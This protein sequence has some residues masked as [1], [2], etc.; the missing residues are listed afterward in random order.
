MGD[1][2]Y[3]CE[4]CGKLY[5]PDRGLNRNQLNEHNR[6]TS[7]SDLD[8]QIV[9]DKDAVLE[10][11]KQSEDKMYDDE[12]YSLKFHS[13]IKNFQFID[14]ECDEKTSTQLSAPIAERE[15]DALQ[16]LG[17]YVIRKLLKKANKLRNNSGENQ[18][19]V[20][21]LTAAKAQHFSH[22][23]LVDAVDRVEVVHESE[24][25][26]LITE[27]VFRNNTS[28]SYYCIQKTS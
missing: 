24:N 25:I 19:I 12:N 26:F 10:L 8:N 6:A 22:M 1:S 13:V 15:R 20:L 9:I 16:Y 27:R 23:K 18:A 17:G 2:N 14:G 4:E 3:S 28:D 7:D 5:R 21:I 11:V